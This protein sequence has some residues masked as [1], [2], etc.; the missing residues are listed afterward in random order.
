MQSK[1]FEKLISSLRETDITELKLEASGSKLSF[2][3]SN[4]AVIAP[5]PAAVS[6]KA[7]AAAPKEEKKLVAVKSPMVGTF[8][9]SDSSDRPPFVMEGNHV[10][11][12]RKVGIIETMKIMKDVSSNV[13]GRIVQVLVKNGQPVEYGQELFL[14]DTEDA[15]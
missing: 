3:R 15:K 13:K 14:V 9:H 1:E 11:P 12:G 10:V 6:A 2:K 7:E 8:F 4:V 5:A